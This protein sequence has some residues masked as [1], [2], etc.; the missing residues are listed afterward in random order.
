[1]TSILNRSDERYDK[2]YDPEKKKLIVTD[3]ETG[4]ITEEE[5]SDE[6][7]KFH[8]MLSGK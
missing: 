1:M 4:K 5:L 6:E 8:E 2:W 7:K 3:M